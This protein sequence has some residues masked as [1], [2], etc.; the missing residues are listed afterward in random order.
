M[1]LDD[2]GQITLR[3]LLAQFPIAPSVNLEE[4]LSDK[5]NSPAS[6]APRGSASAS[7][8]DVAA[9]Q[10]A[11]SNKDNAVDF[12]E[13]KDLVKEIGAD[14]SED[15]LRQLAEESDT[16]QVCELSVSLLPITFLT[17]WTRHRMERSISLNGR[18]QNSPRSF[19]P[20]PG[21]AHLLHQQEAAPH[22]HYLVPEA[23]LKE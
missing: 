4:I 22:P 2:K 20:S 8:N 10:M 5:T 14:I 15:T 21:L 18:R 12:N 7:R 17:C 3:A 1:P 23:Q 6:T 16:N 13:L 11:D 19:L 9:F